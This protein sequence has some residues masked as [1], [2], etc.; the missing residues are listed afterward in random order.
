MKT[1]EKV[2]IY[3]ILGILI[4]GIFNLYNQG[5]SYNSN[6]AAFILAGFSV[7]VAVLVGWQIYNAISIERRTRKL[8][9]R[10]NFAMHR[11]KKAHARI[12]SVADY[13][14]KFSLGVCD[15]ILAMIREQ[16]IIAE[17]NLRQDE[18]LTRRCDAYVFSARAVAAVL[19]THRT[20]PI[21]GAFIGL[22]TATMSRNANQ[23]FNN[24]L[25]EAT[26]L[27]FSNDDHNLCDELFDIVR[28]NA[29][30]LSEDNFNTIMNCRL[31]RRNFSPQS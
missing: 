6:A 2:A 19:S 12:D 13:S 26:A 21:Y 24:E 8:E 23:L 30:L 17:N 3:S 22:A 27:A 14:E 10:T 1:S 15:L 5:I 11:L 25:R 29:S 7:L 4:F 28:D 31:L 20:E 9:S 18:I 16:S